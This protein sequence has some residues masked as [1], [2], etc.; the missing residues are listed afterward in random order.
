MK[1]LAAS[2]VASVIAVLPAGAAQAE[3][4][5]NCVNT[6]EWSHL[7]NGTEND[8]DSPTS[9][10]RRSVIE[11][12]W[13]VTPVGYRN[14]YWQPA[15]NKLYSLAYNFCQN[16]EKLIVVVYRKTSGSWQMAIKGEFV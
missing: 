6:Y 12:T 11:E 2:L 3:R 5:F 8:L 10:A 15:N 1:V 9:S 13:D 16:R 4:Q 7:S 14:R